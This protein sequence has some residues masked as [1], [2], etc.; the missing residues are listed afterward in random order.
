VAPVL[1][2]R[3]IEVVELDA[4]IWMSIGRRTRSKP[5]AGGSR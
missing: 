5:P 2:K 4:S 3:R 1:K